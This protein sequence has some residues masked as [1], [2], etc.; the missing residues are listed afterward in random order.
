MEE[1]KKPKSKKG[2]PRSSPKPKSLNAIDS[3]RRKEQGDIKP[4][5]VMSLK[6]LTLKKHH[7]LGQQEMFPGD[8]SYSSVDPA[9]TLAKQA[10]RKQKRRERQPGVFVP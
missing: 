1:P 6:P 9:R 5:G 2:N 3:K 7:E 4:G 8:L 10:K